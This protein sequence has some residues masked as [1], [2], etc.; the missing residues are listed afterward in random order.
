MRER[1]RPVFG[2]LSLVLMLGLALTAIL[3]TL[4]LPPPPP[5]SDG[6]SIGVVLEAAAD[7]I[8]TLLVLGAVSLSATLLAGV[9]LLRREPPL[10]AAVGLCLAVPALVITLVTIANL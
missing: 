1:K 6:E 4:Y 7:L 3:M 8:G 2:I 5:A 9:G 10:A